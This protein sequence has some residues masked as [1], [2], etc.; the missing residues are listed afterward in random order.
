MDSSARQNKERYT[1]NQQEALR[2]LGYSGQNVDAGMHEQLEAQFKLCENVSST[3]WIYKIF[4]VSCQ[5]NSIALTGTTLVLEGQSIVEHLGEAQYCAVMA[6]T[7][8]LSNE[9][10]L[11]RQRALGGIQAL[12]FDAAGSALVEAAADACNAA[13]IAEAHDEG[14]YTNYRYGPGYGDLSLSIQQNVVK[15]LE[16]D[17]VLGISTTES[18]MLIPQKS[19]TAFVG[20]FERPQNMQPT[21]KRCSFAQYCTLRKKGQTC[22]R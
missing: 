7:C 3:S 15:V 13:I 2:Y 5:D 9:R 19:I 22:Y 4:P 17:K 10:E 12:A 20:L 16:A 6:A 1:V 18:N 11:Q 21:C 8:G 14:L